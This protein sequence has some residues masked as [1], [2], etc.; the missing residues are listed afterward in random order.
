[1][2]KLCKILIN[3]RQVPNTYNYTNTVQFKIYK[4]YVVPI[5][6]ARCTWNYYYKIK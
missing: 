6:T 4:L 5:Q 3:F 2:Y 1:M